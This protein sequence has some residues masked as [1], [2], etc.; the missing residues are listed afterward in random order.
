[1]S[2]WVCCG[3]RIQIFDKNGFL[4]ADTRELKRFRF[5]LRFIVFAA[6]GS[7]QSSP[8]IWLGLIVACRGNGGVE[9][10]S[11]GFFGDDDT[12]EPDSPDVHDI[13]THM[14]QQRP[15]RK[16]AYN[17]SYISCLLSTQ[18]CR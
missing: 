14:T 11:D 7:L 2:P 5:L 15:Q 3:V 8:P 13:D 4:K 6:L 10:C 1:M 17:V 18:Q 16:F 9:S 12:A